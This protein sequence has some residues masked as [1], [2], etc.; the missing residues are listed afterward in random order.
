L[1]KTNF[2][3]IDNYK[4]LEEQT[5]KA[6]STIRSHIKIEQEMKMYLEYLEAQI[7]KMQ[8]QATYDTSID[9][10]KRDL[11]IAHNR[12][13][14]LQREKINLIKKNERLKSEI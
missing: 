7:A 11:C 2:I 14:L 8:R 10:L 4:T 5:Q 3:T 9:H 13:T 12:E 1:V 6:E